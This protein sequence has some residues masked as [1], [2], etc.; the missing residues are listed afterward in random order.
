MAGSGKWA[1]T[2]NANSMRI[3]GIETSCDET[4]AAVVEDGVRV[5]SNVIFSQIPLH[6]A[7]GGVVPEV[8][9]RAHVEKI[10][11][12]IEEALKKAYSSGEMKA[13]QFDNSKFSDGFVCPTILRM[14]PGKQF[15]RNCARTLKNNNLDGESKL[16]K[17]NTSK[18][19]YMSSSGQFFDSIDAIAVTQGPGLLSSLVIGTTAAS[20]LATFWNKPLIPMNHIAGHIYANWL[21]RSTDHVQFP[22]VVLTASGG[23]NELVL[24]RGHDQF[25]L[26]GETL[27]D[28]AGEAFDK[29]ARL[30]G[31]GYPGGPQIARAAHA[32]NAQRYN[33]PKAYMGDVS[34]DFS[35]SGLKT[36]MLNFI[37][38]EHKANGQLNEEFIADCAA[39]FQEAVCGVLSDKLLR[40]AAQ[41][42]A[43]TVI[44]SGGVSANLRLREIIRDKIDE[45][46]FLDMKGR[47]ISLQQKPVFDFPA[48][49]SFCTDNAAMIAG[50]AFFHIQRADGLKKFRSKN[51]L[52]DPNLSLF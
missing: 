43:K 45:G 16:F 5:L 24:M 32:G 37:R 14:V 26:L 40:A 9:A 44:I 38:E 25:Q 49:V 50:S 23:H 52:G 4:S 6:Q 27:D 17:K 10:V 31:M 30:L 12:V 21:N 15:L 29:V 28:A 2:L 8:A 34:F 36:S 35:F 20:T 7:T 33:F 22:C 51:V 11:P 41:F 13:E 42:K 47:K 1:N 46:F 48:D 3:L 39:S 18:N 19:I